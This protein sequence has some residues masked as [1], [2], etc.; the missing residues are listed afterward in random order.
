MHSAQVFTQH[1]KV[2]HVSFQQ[3][4]GQEHN[5]VPCRLELAGYSLAPVDHVHR[6]RYQRGRHMQIHEAAGHAVLAAYGRHLHAVQ[7]RVGPQ[8]CRKGQAPVSFGLHTLEIFLQGKADSI[9]ICS[10]CHSFHHGLGH[11]IHSAVEGTPAGHL[12]IIA[13]GHKGGRV[14][15]SVKDGNLGHH[16]FRRGQLQ[17]APKGHFNR[18]PANGGV[19]PFA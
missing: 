14:R 2:K 7:H 10:H 12:R 18:S 13:V 16:A 6:E 15:M 11:C 5:L 4:C 1:R 3:R 9:R 8:Q 17:L 19:E